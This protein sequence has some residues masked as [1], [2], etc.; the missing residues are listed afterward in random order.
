MKNEATVEAK[1]KTII[2]TADP[3][4]AAILKHFVEIS[5]FTRD[6]V[7]VRDGLTADEMEKLFCLVVLQENDMN[8]RRRLFERYN[9]FKNRSGEVLAQVELKD[10]RWTLAAKANTRATP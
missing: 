2:E 4:A 1:V 7:Q 6:R 9:D 10:N 8:L 3:N 5:E